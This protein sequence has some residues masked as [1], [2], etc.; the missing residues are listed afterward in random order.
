MNTLVLEILRHGSTLAIEED[1]PIIQ[2]SILGKLSSLGKKQAKKARE[3]LALIRYD[4]IFIAASERAERTVRIAIPNLDKHSYSFEIGLCERKYGVW[5][6]R[7]YSEVRPVYRECLSS[8]HLRPE[9]GESLIDAQ[10]RSVRFYREELLPCAERFWCDQETARFLIVGHGTVSICLLFF[11]LFGRNFLDEKEFF[12][13]RRNGLEN[14]SLSSI[15]VEKGNSGYV[16]R[17][18]LW[19]DTSYL[20]P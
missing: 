15:L 16:A 9:N 6:G 19:N 12:D 11:A 20:A 8:I 1:D 13:F 2:D 17:E 7:R 10:E 4:R 5:V 3:A 18:I 14:C